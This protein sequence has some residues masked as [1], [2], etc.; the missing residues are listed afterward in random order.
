MKI[1]FSANSARRLIYITLLAFLFCYQTNAHSYI[2]ELSDVSLYHKKPWEIPEQSQVSVSGIGSILVNTKVRNPFL[3]ETR[4]TGVGAN[5]QA[6]FI[7]SNWGTELSII[8]HT[9]ASKFYRESPDGS[10]DLVESRAILTEGSIKGWV[11]NP[12]LGITAGVELGKQFSPDIDSVESPSKDYTSPMTTLFA[13]NTVVG[14]FYIKYQ[15]EKFTLSS[16]FDRYLSSA[17]VVRYERV[18][19]QKHKSFPL[20]LLT[21]RITSLVNYN[22]NAVTGEIGYTLSRTLSPKLTEGD[23]EL[24]IYSEWLFH[25]IYSSLEIMQRWGVNLKYQFGYGYVNGYANSSEDGKFLIV[26]DIF[27]SHLYG[28]AHWNITSATTVRVYGEQFSVQI[29]DYSYFDFYPFSMW[30]IFKPTRYRFSD[31]TLTATTGGIEGSFEKKWSDKNRTNFGV[32]TSVIRAHSAHYREKQKIIVILPIYTDDTTITAIDSRTIV[33]DITIDHTIDFEKLA[34]TLGASQLIPISHKELTEGSLKDDSDNSEEESEFDSS[35][36]GW[37]G[38]RFHS[39]I[40]VL[41]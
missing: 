21:R 39:S 9:F 27:S 18:V 5:L 36:S 13:D 24:P 14:G 33:G 12:Q 10:I 32:R 4:S 35:T 3:T 20:T 31:V 22:S 16:S 28:S 15:R 41:F 25:K 37:G 40:T 1:L 23:N 19:T 11:F 17:D 7:R 2:D 26:E 6:S 30:S 29:P 34:L 38:L 8:N